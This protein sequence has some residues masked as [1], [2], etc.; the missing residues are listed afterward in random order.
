MREGPRVGASVRLSGPC[1]SAGVSVRAFYCL[2][3][4]ETGRPRRSTETLSAP[5]G[6]E[7]NH[8]QCASVCVRSLSISLSVSLPRTL[9]NGNDAL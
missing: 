1:A 4:G 9:C 2:F 5:S 6:N 3:K 8:T 7:G